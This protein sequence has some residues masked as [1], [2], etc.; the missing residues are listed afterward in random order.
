MYLPALQQQ[1]FEYTLPMIGVLI[2]LFG[3]VVGLN[4]SIWLTPRI[5]NKD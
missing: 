2:F 3:I 5:K 1:L 4:I